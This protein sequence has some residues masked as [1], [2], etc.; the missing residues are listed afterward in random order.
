MFIIFRLRLLRVCGT[1]RLRTEGRSLHPA[2]IVDPLKAA[3]TQTRALE[4]FAS[5]ICTV[6]LKHLENKIVPG[7]TCAAAFRLHKCFMV[8]RKALCKLDGF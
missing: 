7:P 8:D 3:V 5:D 1:R 2:R 6:K 4:Q